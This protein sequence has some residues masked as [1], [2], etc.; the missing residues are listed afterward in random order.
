MKVVLMWR[1]ISKAVSVEKHEWFCLKPFEPVLFVLGFVRCLTVLPPLILLMS[2]GQ[3][4]RRPHVSR[5]RVET[6]RGV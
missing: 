1:T 6:I 2:V 3:C 5:R 4:G